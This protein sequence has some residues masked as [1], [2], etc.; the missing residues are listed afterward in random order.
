MQCAFP[1][2]PADVKTLPRLQHESKFRVLGKGFQRCL[3][4]LG[5]AGK[6]LSSIQTADLAWALCGTTH[7]A[8][9]RKL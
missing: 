1:C 2:S 8:G 6:C 4:L 9:V 7:F 5:T 3:A